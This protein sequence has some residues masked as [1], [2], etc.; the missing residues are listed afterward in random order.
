MMHN[1]TYAAE[2]ARSVSSEAQAIVGARQL[3]IKA[4]NANAR[5][6]AWRGPRRRRSHCWCADRRAAPSTPRRG[7]RPPA[8]PAALHVRVEWYASS[9]IVKTPSIRTSASAVRD[10]GFV[11]PRPRD[12]RPSGGACARRRRSLRSTSVARTSS[13]P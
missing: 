6:C 9:R 8:P 4:T 2:I 7:G 13:V 11:V 1:R 10:D 5:G 3:N 12:K